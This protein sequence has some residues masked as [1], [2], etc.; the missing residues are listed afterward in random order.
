MSGTF[1]RYGNIL[2][3]IAAVMATMSVYVTT[4]SHASS[5]TTNHQPHTVLVPAL[6]YPQSGLR[7]RLSD[8]GKTLPAI[9]NSLQADIPGLYY[10]PR[11]IGTDIPDANRHPAIV[12]LPDCDDHFPEDWINILRDLGIGVLVISPNRAHPSQAYCSEGSLGNP[13]HGLTYWAFDG[14]SALDYLAKQPDIDPERIAIF[15]YGYGGGAAQLAIYRDGHAKH[16]SARFRALIGL[17]PQCMSEMNNFAPSL[18]IALRGDPFNP[19]AWCQWRMDRDLTPARA[20]VRFELIGNGE[21][22]EKQATRKVVAP[23]KSPE[24]VS[25]VTEFLSQSGVITKNREN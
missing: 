6:P 2:L 20:L 19:P 3:R 21:T 22:V 4:I 12:A 9:D 15:G 17:R 13:K 23:E 7:K 5:D 11:Q 18:L 1:K 16:F 24:V 25:I 14:L 8:A 10:P